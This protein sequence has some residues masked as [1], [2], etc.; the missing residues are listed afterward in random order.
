[1]N[2]ILAILALLI[3]SALPSFGV[4]TL[5]QSTLGG[6]N[7]ATLSTGGTLTSSAVAFTNNTAGGTGDLV[8]MVVWVRQ[9][10][11]GG[12]VHGLLSTAFSCMTSGVTWTNTASLGFGEFIDNATAHH[13][14]DEYVC[15]SIGGSSISN[16]TTSTASVTLPSNNNVTASIE[17]ALFEFSGVNAFVSPILGPPPN[18]TGTATNPA[19]SSSVGASP[20]LIIL[21]LVGFPG[22]N[23][24][25]ASGWTLGPNAG[26]ATIGQ[27][28][29]NLGA[30]GTISTQFSG[31]LG[32]WAMSGP[33]FSLL[34]SST[35]V[36][37][38]RGFVN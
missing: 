25:A 20:R 35:S 29:Y 30:T 6:H 13:A 24:T 36:P 27:T 15:Y 19:E 33:A 3:S 34:T 4:A 11:V 10:A 8:V 2:K 12:T 18:D 31:T 17:F 22:S 23:L 14:G 21:N 26:T 7:T 1:M 28:S 37:R 32:L 9:D 16:S 5:V 38:H